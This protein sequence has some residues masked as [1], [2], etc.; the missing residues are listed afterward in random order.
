MQ[1]NIQGQMWDVTPNVPISKVDPLIQLNL[2]INDTFVD[3]LT[4]IKLSTQINGLTLIC[5]PQ[6]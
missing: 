4:F 1:K 5:K 6:S 3:K 2:K